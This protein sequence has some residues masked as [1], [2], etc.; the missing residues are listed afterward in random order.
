MPTAATGCSRSSTGFA[1]DNFLGMT[2]SDYGGG[3]PIVDV[4]RRDCGLAVGHLELTPRLVSLPVKEQQRRRACLRSMREAQADSCAPGESSRRS[5][6]SWPPIRGD[7]F[8][9]LD[10]YRRLMGE[11]GLRAPQPPEASYEPIWC[12]WGYERDCT[13]EL[14]EGTLPKVRELG[15]VLG[16]A[17]M[18]A[19]SP[20]WATGTSHRGS[21]RGGEADM[22]R[23]VGRI[24]EQGL[25]PRLWWAPLAAAPGSDLL[26]DHTDMLLLDKDGAVQ[27]I[28]WWNSFYL[29]PAYDKTV[30][31]TLDLVR[32]FIGEWGYRGPE[33][34]RTTSERR[35]AVLQS[36]APPR[37]AGRIDGETARVLSR[38]LRHGHA[39]QSGGGH[40][41]VPLRHLL[42]VL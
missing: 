20:T 38:H 9:T 29:C 31:Y 12:A 41:A 33:D 34:R 39:D 11:R 32:K 42:L 23:L 35:G 3:T 21:F 24:Q 13:V 2:A 5:R 22:R 6:P 26:H 18:T 30:A 27:N 1:Q 40:R 4:W 10:S 8:A 36:R 16:G 15:L 25:K 17:S 7:Y 14:I 19:G 28:T 37:P